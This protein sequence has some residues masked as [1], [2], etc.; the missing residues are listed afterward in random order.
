MFVGIKTHT[1]YG[2]SGN[3][4]PPKPVDSK[5]TA[6]LIDVESHEEALAIMKDKVLPLREAAAK[7]CEPYSAPDSWSWSVIELESE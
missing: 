3:E 2:I 4:L 6:I 5:V 1:I 7:I